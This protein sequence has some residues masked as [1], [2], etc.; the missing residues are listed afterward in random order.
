MV[1]LEGS[2][3]WRRESGNENAKLGFQWPDVMAA[4][5][6][7]MHWLSKK[8]M[9]CSV[10]FGNEGGGWRGSARLSWFD[11]LLSSQSQKGENERGRTDERTITVH[12]RFKKKMC[13]FFDSQGY[14]EVTAAQG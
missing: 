9:P 12:P 1:R 10:G 2:L 8:S 14:C 13:F 7:V 11:L 3:G 6:R 4:G 5:R